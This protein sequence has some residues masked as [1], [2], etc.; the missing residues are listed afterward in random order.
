MEKYDLAADRVA[1][2]GFSQGAM[3]SLY[4]GPR[5]PERLAGILAYSGAL[6]GGQA[7]DQ[8]GIFKVP[9][10][11][12]HGDEDNVVPVQNYYDAEKTLKNTGFSVTG[13]VTHGLGHSIDE[14]GVGDGGNFLEL[15]LTWFSLN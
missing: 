1:L 3:M 13:G 12:I 4:N 8:E 6:V 15:I 9:V 7:L 2:G 11:L 14:K 5:F 10:H